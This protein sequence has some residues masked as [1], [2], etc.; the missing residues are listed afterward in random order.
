MSTITIMA[1]AHTH[2]LSVW[3]FHGHCKHW[4]SLKEWK[5]TLK[6]A[7]PCT[8]THASISRRRRKSAPRKQREPIRRHEA[9]S[10]W[11][12]FKETLSSFLLPPAFDGAAFWSRLQ[13]SFDLRYW[14]STEQ[15]GEMGGGSGGWGGVALVSLAMKAAPP[16]RTLNPYLELYL[17]LER[18]NSATWWCM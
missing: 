11:D 15:R 12:A 10:L 13:L 3:S 16:L 17:Y 5:V 8:R 14:T 2:T 18:A 4:H 9:P 1:H 6:K 7:L